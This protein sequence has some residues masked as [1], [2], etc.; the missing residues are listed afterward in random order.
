MAVIDCVIYGKANRKRRRSTRA[1]LYPVLAGV[2]CALLARCWHQ[3]GCEHLDKLSPSST[4]PTRPET[5]RSSLTSVSDWLK[6]YPLRRGTLEKSSTSD[7]ME[8]LL[9]SS[10]ASMMK[11]PTLCSELPSPRPAHLG[12]VAAHSIS[13]YVRRWD[14]R[15][16][17]HA[18]TRCLSGT[19]QPPDAPI[20]QI[21]SLQPTASVS[22]IPL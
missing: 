9:G 2:A 15:R 4:L 1:A 14:G 22:V 5:P 13:S 8:R 12:W 20:E 7:G 6:R 18:I 17:P 3:P 19:S 16:V 11:L 10:T 21:I